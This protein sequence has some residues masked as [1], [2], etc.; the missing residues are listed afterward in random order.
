MFYSC[1]KFSINRKLWDYFEDLADPCKAYAKSGDKIEINVKVPELREFYIHK[2]YPLTEEHIR[3]KEVWKMLS[4]E[5]YVGLCP[6][7]FPFIYGSFVCDNTLHFI[8]QPYSLSLDMVTPVYPQKWWAEVLYQ[9]AK[10]VEYL[11]L[12][13]INHNNLIPSNV[14]FQEYN[15]DTDRLAV[16]ITDLSK[17]S[18]A[19]FTPGK[20]MLQ[21]LNALIKK[22]LLKR[23]LINVLTGIDI[24]TGRNVATAL[25]NTYKV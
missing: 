4:T 12:R 3:G 24:Y 25:K 23:E 11:E 15:M 18:T 14:A 9:V 17:S 22:N 13:G 21:L 6:L 1:K 16:M 20:D 10:G 8:L 7:L 19:N 5:M 2:K